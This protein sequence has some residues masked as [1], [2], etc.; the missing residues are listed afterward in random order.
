MLLRDMTAGWLVREV[1]MLTAREIDLSRV[2]QFY[3]RRRVARRSHLAVER[4]T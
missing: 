4:R 2:G 1:G 3:S